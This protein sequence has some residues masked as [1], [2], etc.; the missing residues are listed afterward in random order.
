MGHFGMIRRLS[1]LPPKKTLI[2]YIKK[3]VALNDA[4][5]SVPRKPKSAAP[6]TVTVPA[7]LTAALK[8]N[9]KAQTAFDAFRPSHK[10][11]YIEWIT[12]AKRDE[13][14]ARR[15]KTAVAQMAEGKPHNWKYM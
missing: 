5:V 3:A 4:G 9:K 2:A 10:R 15:L 12:E 8:K 7:D 11:E 6:K 13:T 14:R 1:D